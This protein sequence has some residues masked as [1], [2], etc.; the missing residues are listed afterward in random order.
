MAEEIRCAAFGY[1]GIG[2]PKRGF[3][4]TLSSDAFLNFQRKYLTPHGS[5]ISMSNFS[6]PNA[7]IAKIKQ[8]IKE[9][10]PECTSGLI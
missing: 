8:K 7:A 2:M 9:R 1:S 6:D 4:N 10:Y 5:I 3:G